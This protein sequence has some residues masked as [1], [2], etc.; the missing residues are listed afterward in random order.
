MKHVTIAIDGASMAN[1]LHILPPEF[2]RGDTHYLIHHSPKVQYQIKNGK[3]V[4][5]KNFDLLLDF[6][7][8]AGKITSGVLKTDY[9]SF[10]RLP[11]TEQLIQIQRWLNNTQLANSNLEVPN[12]YLSFGDIGDIELSTHGTPRTA[13][14]VVKRENG[15]GGA[16]QA[17]VPR[18]VLSLLLA[19]LENENYTR[20]ELVERYPTVTFSEEPATGSFAVKD[21]WLVMDY[22]EDIVQEYRILIGGKTLMGYQRRRHDT[23]YPQAN[24]FNGTFNTSEEIQP[25]DFDS[26][27]SSRPDLCRDLLKLIRCMGLRFGSIDLYIR[28]NGQAG[29]FEFCPQYGFYLIDPTVIRQLHEDFIVD[30]VDLWRG[31]QKVGSDCGTA[32]L[33]TAET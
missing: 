22:L 2:T 1:N 7:A 28:N 23:P 8:S 17:I 30:E 5:H 14:V 31:L 29:I 18:E 3:T 10:K 16:S 15:A 27:F 33:A 24:H 19:D 11:K 4:I 6:S 32:P 25:E 12:H 20:D 26:L 13:R 21:H 9:R